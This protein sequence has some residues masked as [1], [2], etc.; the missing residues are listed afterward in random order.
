[1]NKPKADIAVAL[2][3]RENGETRLSMRSRQM[4][5]LNIA[6]YFGGGGHKLAAGATVSGTFEEALEKVLKAFDNEC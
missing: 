5:V 3:E 2:W 6:E 4:N 1:M